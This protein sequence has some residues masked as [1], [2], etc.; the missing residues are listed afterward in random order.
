M[1]LFHPFLCSGVLKKNY[2]NFKKDVK[3]IC[4]D[5]LNQVV[6]NV[7]MTANAGLVFLINNAKQDNTLLCKDFSPVV[8]VKVREALWVKQV[9]APFML[10]TPLVLSSIEN[11]DS[12]Q[13]FTPNKKTKWAT[14][15]IGKWAD[16]DIFCGGSEKDD[17]SCGLDE[18]DFY[19][20]GPPFHLGIRT[21]EEPI[22]IK[23]INKNILGVHSLGWSVVGLQGTLVYPRGI[24]HAK[25][26]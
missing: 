13:W 12:D 22:D 16:V 6:K 21:V 19:L 10:T 11:P 18:K 8:F 5:F 24:S 14:G 25:I 2:V 17:F 20:F 23:M 9:P 7:I 4:E 1:F 3:G 15:R 26:G